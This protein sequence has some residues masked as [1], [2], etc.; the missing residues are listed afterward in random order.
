VL[1]A[2]AH[3]LRSNAGEWQLSPAQERLWFLDQLDPGNPAYNIPNA[4]RL[5]G[6]LDVAALTRSL[7]DLV[8][9]HEVL[10]SRF[11][12]VGGR[13]RV[14]V[15]PA[16]TLS[17]EAQDVPGSTPAAREAA[18]ARLAGA[19]ARRR[20]D[21]AAGPLVHAQ[22]WR[23]A[24]TDHVLLLTLHHIV[25]D[26]WSLE[27]MVREL[28]ALYPAH[29]A[30]RP[31]T[32][33]ELPIQYVDYAA[34]QREWLDSA[35]QVQGHLDYWKQQLADLPA[36]LLPTDSPRPPAPTGRGAAHRFQWPRELLNQLDALGQ[37]HKATLFMV[38][39]AGLQTL[40]A[41][42]SGQDDVAVGTPIANRQRTELEGLVGYFVN[43]LV[44]RT[45]FNDLAGPLSFT[46]LL[47]HV[48]DI[49]LAAYTHQELP[50]ERVVEALHPTRS[51]NP[52][53]LIQAMLVMQGM[54]VSHLQLGELRLSAM[55]VDSDTT[56]F[57]LA[58]IFSVAE[59]GLA[60][61]VE[62]ST[63]LF[64]PATIARLMEHFK[65]LLES[66]VARPESPLWSLPLL[67][68]V[69]QQRLTDWSSPRPAAAESRC[70]HQLFEV[71]VTRRPDAIAV[72]C[73]PDQL[74]YAE[75]NRRANQL[76]HFLQR[77]GVGPEVLVGL[78]VERSLEMVVGLLGVLK[79]G[80][81]YIPI[82]PLL[83]PDRLA[84]MVHDSGIEMLLTQARL[85]DKLPAGVRH[86]FHLDGDWS[87]LAHE[88][89]DNPA[90]GVTPENLAYVPYTSGTT[91]QPKGSQIPHRS[92]PGFIFDVDYVAWDS[93][94]TWLQYSSISWDALTLELWP[95]LLLGGRCVLYS[96]QGA[97]PGELGGEIQAERVSILWLTVALF[98]ALLE[99]AP[100]ILGTVPKVLVGGEALSPG[101]IRRALET[102][103]QT[104]LVNGYGPSECTVF[105][106]C[107]PI[108][109]Q[110][111][112]W[113]ETIPV[114]YPIG[115]RRVYLLDKHF[116]QVPA[117]VPGE[118]YVG[119]PSVARGYLQHP[120]LTAEKF[121]PD[122]FA[123]PSTP[124]HATGMGGAGGRLYRSGDL[125]RW[126][127]DGRVE[128]IGRADHQVKIR[129]FRVEL[130]EIENVLG[131]HPAVRDAVILA[132][133]D[134][135]GQKRLVGYVVL[136][137]STPTR[138]LR[139]YLKDRLPEYMVPAAFVVLDSMPLTSTGKLNR[140]A[141]PAPE[142]V[143]PDSD[144]LF[145]APR[146]P[147][148]K[149][150]AKIWAEILGLDQVG[151]DDNFFDLGGHSLLLTQLVSRLRTTF[152]IELPLRTLFESPTIAQ[153]AVA[154]VQKQSEEI[155]GELLTQLLTRLEGR[156]GDRS[157][158]ASH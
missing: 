97:S 57:D 117:G 26:G 139:E 79:A 109:R 154:I 11:T 157:Q 63:D 46:R 155:D 106:C 119:G 17:L 3:A 150:V 89:A 78:C 75:L 69:E 56:K 44:I 134:A 2:R 123:A 6:P 138:E 107:Y 5:Q 81:A 83:P 158:D 60:G 118:L 93:H 73:G 30:G 149:E 50:F 31:S 28:A 130:G 29:A 8:G 87:R 54:P 98:N 103:P 137:T 125:C 65:I 156:P 96:G 116:N 23:L 153:L 38:L 47:E 146:T 18:L 37:R 68:P 135:G 21:L 101:H 131:Q 120:A 7:N 113:G 58:I 122:P 42:Y 71:Q 111:E 94:D 34:W 85:A 121:V 143:Q 14:V 1:L 90:S 72:V 132:S 4:T 133:T 9:R 142:T 53:P 147:L 59:D 126:L 110:V 151:I 52:N 140:R 124:P 144:T 49:C 92:I 99:V 112:R 45:R 82:D 88:Q 67:T 13:P 12:G 145:V 16:L 102:C 104:Q 91:G 10:R 36:L 66:I 20:F 80:G 55:A 24:E 100:E 61:T 48:R 32:L 105:T 86:I 136:N 84:F 152:K 77:Q 39:M 129:G 114:G 22:L 43:T 128:F 74:S 51:L 95:A 27:L 64:S 25:A 19:E 41:R 141:L 15:E 108:P 127:P 40:L 76:A 35:D 115:D 62:Y 33:P 148:E 70:V